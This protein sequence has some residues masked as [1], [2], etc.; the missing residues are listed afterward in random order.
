MDSKKLLQLLGSLVMVFV[1]AAFTGPQDSSAQSTWYV[2]STEGDDNND[3]SQ[4]NNAGAG[5]GPFATI[6]KGISEASDGD[7]I[8]ILA[9]TYNEDIDPEAS[10][11]GI[12]NLTFQVQASGGNTIVF[13][14]DLNIDEDQSLSG[15]NGKFRVTGGDVRLTDGALTVAS[16][17]LELAAGVSVEVND[18]SVSGNN[19]VYLGDGS[20]RYDPTNTGGSPATITTGLEL[21]S[22]G[23]LGGGTLS[24]D[25]AFDSGSLTVDQAITAGAV[26]LNGDAAV[27]FQQSV[28]GTA[29]DIDGAGDVAFNS[30]VSGGDFDVTGASDVTVTGNMTLSADLS[31]EGTA[32]AGSFTANGTV[33]ALSITID[34]D[35]DVDFNGAVSVTGGNFDHDGSGDV[36]TGDVDLNGNN[37]VQTDGTFT[38][39]STLT[40]GDIDADGV[41]ISNAA[42]ASMTI[43]N[44]VLE[45][46]DNTGEDGTA[47]DTDESVYATIDNNGTFVI[48]GSI[49]EQTVVDDDDADEDVTHA[50][51]IDNAD[52]AL[53]TINATTGFSGDVTNAASNFNNN[54]GDAIQDEGIAVGA[55]NTVTASFAGAFT[56]LGYWG[57]GTL[58]ITAGTAAI[59]DL[60]TVGGLTLS[61]ARA[62]TTTDLVATGNVDLQADGPVTHATVLDVGGT[63]TVSGDDITINDGAGTHELDGLTVTGDDFTYGDGDDTINVDGNAT[64]SDAT[65]DGAL[66][67]DSGNF[68][69]DGGTVTGALGVEG[70]ATFSGAVTLDSTFD[71]DGAATINAGSTVSA[72][73]FAASDIGGAFTVNGTFDGTG[74][75][76]SLT[77][78]SATIAIPAGILD[79]D[80]ADFTLG[81]DFTG[82]TLTDAGDVTINIP[83]GGATFSPGPNTTVDGFTADGS[84]RTVTVSE[85]FTVSDNGV[86]VNNDATLALGDNTVTIGA[87]GL[88]LEDEAQITTSST[89]GAVAFNGGAQD[90]TVTG[91]P[92]TD[93][94]ISNIRVNGTATVTVRNDIDITGDL[95]LNNGTFVVDTGDTVNMTGSSA[96]ITRNPSTGTLTVNGTLAGSWDVVYFGAAGTTSGEFSDGQTKSA[97][98]NMTSGATLTIDDAADLSG[99][100]TVTDGIVVIDANVGVAGN[101]SLNAAADGFTVNGGD[102]FDVDG[103][104]TFSDP[105]TITGAWT[106]A[107]AFTV[108][109]GVVVSGAGSFTVDGDATSS[110]EGSLTVATTFDSNHTV[111]GTTDDDAG[112]AVFGAVTVD[113]DAVVSLNEIQETAAVTVTDGTLNLDM[114]DDGTNNP[115]I[116][117]AITVTE[118]ALTLSGDDEIRDIDSI[119]IDEGASLTLN[120]VDA[121]SDGTVDVGDGGAG[122]ATLDLGGRTLEVGG[123]FEADAD[124]SLGTTGTVNVDG[125]G[126]IDVNGNTIPNLTLT[127]VDELL[128]NATVSGLLNV[129]D[130][131]D[132][133]GFTLTLSGDAQ[134]D[135][136]FTNG[137]FATTGTTLTLESDT[138]VDNFTVNSSSTTTIV[139]DDTTAPI[140]NRTFTVNGDFT[141]EA[142]SLAIG[143]ETLDI[144]GGDFDYNVATGGAITMGDGEVHFSAATAFDSDDVNV[145]LKNVQVDGLIDMTVDPGNG[146]TITGTANLDVSPSVTTDDANAATT[147]STVTFGNGSTIIVSATG[148]LALF[149]DAPTLG[150]GMK[151]EYDGGAATTAGNELPSAVATFETD[152]TDFAFLDGVSLTADAIIL[153]GGIDIDPFDDSDQTFTLTSGGTITYENDADVEA[154]DSFTLAGD[155]NVVFNGLTPLTDNEWPNAYAAPLTMDVNSA[156]TMHEARTTVDLAVDAALTVAGGGSLTVTGDLSIE[157]TGSFVTSATELIIMAGSAAQ[158]ITVAAGGTTPG[159]LG[160][161][162][163]AGVTIDSDLD[164]EGGTL[165]LTDGPLIT[166]TNTVTLDHGGTGAQGYT[167]TDGVIFGNVQKGI[168]T[169]GT[170]PNRVEFPLGDAAGNYRPFAITFNDP[171][172]DIGDLNGGADDIQLTVGYVASSPG[173]SNGLPISTTDSQGNA[174]SIGRYP[175]FHWNIESAPTVSPSVDYD[176]EFQAEGYSAFDQEDVER[177]R[178]IRRQDGATTNFWI[179]AAP[180]AGDNDNF[181]VSSTEPVAVARNAVGAVNSNGV[182]F[183]FGL[184]QN[185][186]ATDPAAL[187]LNAGNSETVDLTTVF[188]GGS[189]SYTYAVT[190]NNSGVVTGAAAGDILTVTGVA[191]GSGTITVVATDDFGTT[192]TATVTATVNAALSSSA[193]TNL[194]PVSVGAAD[195][196][197]DGSTAIAG[198]TTPYTYTV[199]SDDTAVATA[200]V[201]AAT[202]VITVTFVGQGT[203]TITLTA[204]DAEGDAVT[205]TFTVTVNPAASAG[206][207]LTDQVVTNGNTVDQDVSGEFAGGTG[208]FTY[209]AA[210]SD[211]AIATAAAS[212]STVTTTGVQPYVLTAGSV[213]ADAGPATITVTATD[214][215]GSA[216]SSTYDV[217]V[218]PVL[219]NVDGSGGASPASASLALDAFLGLATLTAKQTTAADYNTDAS[220]TPFDAA[221]IFDAWLNPTP[222]AAS[223]KEFAANP[224]SDVAF[225]EVAMQVTKVTIPVTLTGDNAAAV[226]FNFETLINTELATVTGVTGAVEGWTVKHMIGED[227]TLRIA[228][229]GLEAIPSDGVV[230]NISIE[231]TNAGNEFA[232]KGQGA[233]N[234]N[235]ATELEGIDVVE[236]PEDFALLGNYPNPFNPSTNISF[237]LP[238]S[239]EVTVEVYDMLGRRVMVL[240]VQTVQAGAK[241]S[242]QLNASQLASGSYFYR[243]I[244]QMES[245]TQVDNGRMLL[246]K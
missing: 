161:N 229:F 208:G 32:D 193:L 185:M 167:R 108:A 127:G 200:T 173:G 172:N 210:S 3:G 140:T 199:A 132:L 21:P 195:A 37:L 75:G 176:V 124:A 61:A 146:L 231:L 114:A 39:S 73:A 219:G 129:D 228:G 187:T 121:D 126:D 64:I 118:G 212:G 156:L 43:D 9:G 165:V 184:E 12:E 159:A 93:P 139:T 5:V 79:L 143:D 25:A 225:G 70:T 77:V 192:A 152:N 236:L 221:L 24:T 90:I 105:A 31:I 171:A 19:F 235:P 217:T 59:D 170:N 20:V 174:L 155:W 72:A 68:T 122:A 69:T 49:T 222:G 53:F 239:A 120:G 18:G 110:L 180:T 16:G 4:I 131:L 97:T 223:K 158:S 74:T 138:D 149:D 227:G 23:A 216:V 179:A 144:A 245:K 196:T 98:V 58:A 202:G 55:S 232:L 233:V 215:L 119:D 153:D 38:M 147:N 123:N 45:S 151:V 67:V 6:D 190:N 13:I 166:G 145:S 81:G 87:G 107:G 54:T 175:D 101:F 238:A 40:V 11:A 189:E 46:I 204:T 182:L 177:M 206:G 241:R 162:N 76:T 197:V 203:A 34:G 100:F 65:I 57:G 213:T 1:L 164:M 80:D 7:T 103:T 51:A 205:S 112:D 237:D 115:E 130:A 218:N 88:T 224:A 66:D 207:T 2:N 83:S 36:T 56:D 47:L 240:P 22:D 14:E 52:D 48:N 60:E 181:A 89:A 183:T 15:G 106:Q 211:D 41:R 50:L 117:G 44:I 135:A 96:T 62:I 63:L 214:A 116:D 134:F 128:S 30:T 178:A 104:S 169:S 226:S 33:T 242:I 111:N 246:I 188:F 157:D 136:D 160:I 109:S 27:T 163:A 137:T 244:A 243:V 92:T 230:A 141:M 209:T 10:N 99:N 201:D 28:G 154:G 194:D 84:G 17:I 113:N 168:E 86:D 150:T 71:V 102:T 26:D 29:I 95:A 125:G 94:S 198:G 220:V 8:V 82:G 142:G 78:G 42:G 186:G 234:N 91:A 85:G 148:V 191:A 35:D 133:G